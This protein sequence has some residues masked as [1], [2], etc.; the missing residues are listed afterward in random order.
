MTP[1]L[2]GQPPKTSLFQPKQGSFGFQVHNYVEIGA[3]DYSGL[4][5]F[6]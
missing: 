5:I 6:G 2:E 4:Y 3:G 1:I